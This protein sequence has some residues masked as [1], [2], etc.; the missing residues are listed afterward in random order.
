MGQHNGSSMSP[1][2]WQKKGSE[3]IVEQWVRNRG[4][5]MGLKQWQN[6]ESKTMAE[7]WF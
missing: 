4:R 7:Q 3:A 5:T 2:Q 6:N 1:K